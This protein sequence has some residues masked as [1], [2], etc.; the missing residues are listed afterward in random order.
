MNPALILSTNVQ[1]DGLD[2]D[3]ATSTPSDICDSSLELLQST[4]DQ[5]TRLEESKH[6][7][8]IRYLVNKYPIDMERIEQIFSD[9]KEELRDEQEHYF[10]DAEE[11]FDDYKKLVAQDE[12]F[13]H[14]EKIM[15]EYNSIRARYLDE[16]F[17]LNP[18]SCDNAS[19]STEFTR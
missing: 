2:A 15:A 6:T 1:R 12:Y 9:Y 4:I 11:I 13:T 18:N 17:A 14:A 7:D 8:Y 16:N 19:Q 3:Y 10:D 5:L